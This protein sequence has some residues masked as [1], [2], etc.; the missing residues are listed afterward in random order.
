MRFEDHPGILLINNMHQ[1]SKLRDAIRQ[2]LKRMNVSRYD[3]F[4]IIVD[5]TMM[6]DEFKYA[7]NLRVYDVRSKKR[8]PILS[9]WADTRDELI[10]NAT[11]GKLLFLFNS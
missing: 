2:Y 3:D 10:D 9:I 8:D 7:F 6:H 11:L 4:G 1:A 5:F